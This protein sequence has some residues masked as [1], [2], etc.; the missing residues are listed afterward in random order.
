MCAALAVVIG[1]PVPAILLAALA[2]LLAFT[3]VYLSQHF[4]E[5][6]LAGAFVGTVVT[7]GVYYLLYRTAWGERTALDGGPFRPLEQ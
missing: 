5:D 2:A 4:T 7:I 6:V 3:R 1:K